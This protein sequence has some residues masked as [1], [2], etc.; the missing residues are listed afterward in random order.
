MAETISRTLARE[1]GISAAV[2]DALRD[3]PERKRTR[4]ARVT[5]S[6]PVIADA[7]TDDEGN[8]IPRPP[9]GTRITIGAASRKYEVAQPNVTR[10]AKRGRIHVYEAQRGKGYPTE[11]DEADVYDAV[12]LYRRAPGPGRNPLGLPRSIA[13]RAQLAAAS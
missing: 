9:K 4:K 8:V 5:N 3:D 12:V 11:V 1:T 10:W 6:K 13:S 2:W 7:L